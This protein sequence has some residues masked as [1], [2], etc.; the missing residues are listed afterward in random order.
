MRQK[1]AMHIQGSTISMFCA[2]FFNKVTQQSANKA[3]IY[4]HALGL[5]TSSSF[6]CF[7][8]PL[9]LTIR[10]KTASYYVS[11][12]LPIG[13]CCLSGAFGYQL[14]HID[15]KG[16]NSFFLHKYAMGPKWADT[17]IFDSPQDVSALL[18][19]T[20]PERAKDI[21]LKQPHTNVLRLQ[22]Y[23]MQ[24][25]WLQHYALCGICFCFV[26]VWAVGCG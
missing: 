16:C 14:V 4:S 9:S 8:Q 5:G 20:G 22:W 13:Q 23:A 12:L 21:N 1:A 11:S 25:L 17:P 18:A 10:K 26:H 3:M 7:Y 2:T 6:C 24:T 19:F 15:Q